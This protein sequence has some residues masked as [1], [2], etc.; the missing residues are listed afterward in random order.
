MET[1]N[2]KEP[3]NQEEENELKKLKI[4]NKTARKSIIRKKKGKKVVNTKEEYN[5][6]KN[7]F[8]ELILN[9][10]AKKI[11]K[12]QRARLQLRT[13]NIKKKRRTKLRDLKLLTT[14]MDAPADSN[15]NSLSFDLPYNTPNNR[16]SS[17]ARR[18]YIFDQNSHY[19]S[20][21]KK[22]QNSSL[23][24]V[25]EAKNQKTEMNFFGVQG[26]KTQIH[27]KKDGVLKR[28]K[29]PKLEYSPNSSELYEMDK[30]IEERKLGIRIP[31]GSR[32]GLRVPVKARDSQEYMK[33]WVEKYSKRSKLSKSS[34]ISSRKEGL[35]SSQIS[36]S[37]SNRKLQLGY[38]LKGK[39][40]KAVRRIKMF[41][42]IKEEN[43]IDKQ[44]KKLDDA[45]SKL[46][47]P[48]DLKSSNYYIADLRNFYFSGKKTAQAQII[49]DHFHNSFEIAR[50]KILYEPANELELKQKRIL[51]REGEEGYEETK[52]LLL[53]LDGT[54]IDSEIISEE[55]GKNVIKVQEPGGG[56]IS[57]VRN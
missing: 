33:P 31:T 14:S 12:S 34:C 23:V 43:K 39:M 29:V 22:E 1:E 52:I 49:K 15:F 30:I 40:K 17:V 57:Y 54:L 19:S 50:N 11:P 28:I 6:T 38:S 18:T 44:K 35:N 46:Y 3:Q 51:L 45:L 42:E 20:S 21:P 5:R 56:A 55:K 25:I 7:L 9:V 47:L 26:S 48:Q 37:G 36:H 32:K 13:S 16:V 10:G 8:K 27:Y 4:S 41:R 53:D 2:Q 24:K